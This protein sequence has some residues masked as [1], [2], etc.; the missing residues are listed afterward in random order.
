M[1]KYD[2]IL[3]DR[4]IV[5]RYNSLSSIHADQLP[6]DIKEVFK[7]S[8]FISANVPLVSSAL[9]KMSI[10]TMTSIQYQTEDLSEV[11]EGD[12]TSWKRILEDEMDIKNV[13]QD[14]GFNKLLYGN[15]FLSVNTPVSRVLECKLCKEKSNEMTFGQIQLKPFLLLKDKPGEKFV[16]KG[17]C[18]KCKKESEFSPHDTVVKDAKKINIIQWPVSG[19]LMNKDLITGKGTFYYKMESTYEK[20]IKDGHKDQLFH[21]PL[22]TMIAALKGT[23]IKFDDSRVLHLPRRTLQGSKSAWGVPI[24]TSSIPDMFSLLL[25]RKANEKI[26]SDMIFP[27]RSLSPDTKGMDGSSIYNYMD[28]GDMSGKI[29]AILQSHKNDPTS[30][31]YFP[32]PLRANT[33]FG[34]GKSLNLAREIREMGEDIIG[35]IGV[36]L[37]FVKGGLS[38]NSGGASIRILE[39]QLRDLTASIE[40][41]M[42]FIAMHVGVI[43]GKKPVRLKLIPFKLVDDI[44]DKQIALGMHE[45]GKLSDHTM[46]DMLGIDAQTESDRMIAEQ[47][48]GARMQMEIQKYMQGIAQ[49][50]AEKAETEAMLNSSSTQQLNQQAIM[51]EADNMAQTLSQLPD[52]Q[53]RSEMD[54]LQKENWILYVATKE[55]LEFNERKNI[56]EAKNNN[57]EQGM[58]DQGGESAQ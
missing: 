18:P 51:Q 32:V 55:R 45:K 19:I 8:E 52:G 7:W 36:P 21:L 44:Q 53:K 3:F 2:S 38:Y 4:K 28:A 29:N 39:N 22:N 35:S 58:A 14:I 10:V 20:T 43:M 54:R 23:S 6:N 13:A 26:F 16:I 30:V 27:L 11:D 1:G 24:L 17:I 9:E 34:E 50:L 33:V 42:N 37:E 31:K 46:A 15:V 12:Q 48:L 56:T 57:Q 41:A 5:G 25:A 47:K 40:K 49:N